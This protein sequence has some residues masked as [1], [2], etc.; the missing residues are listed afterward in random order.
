MHAG[1]VCCAGPLSLDKE[2]YS[3]LLATGQFEQ[4]NLDVDEV[5]GERDG[6]RGREISTE[7]CSS[8]RA[9]QALSI[10]IGSGCVKPSL[11]QSAAKS[12]ILNLAACCAGCFRFCRQNTAWSCTHL[13]LPKS[14]GRLS[15]EP[16]PLPFLSGQQ[17]F[18][19]SCMA[20]ASKLNRPWS[21]CCRTS[22][23]CQVQAFR[24]PA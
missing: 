7:E 23:A 8:S 2:V 17:G 12:V 16:Q 3:Q 5:R 21:E 4:M 15:L 1:A 13:T 24:D 20:D 22:S 6:E 9:S 19:C 14:W 10:H 18:R 11:A